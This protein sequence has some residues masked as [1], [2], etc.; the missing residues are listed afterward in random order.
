MAKVRATVEEAQLSLMSIS[1]STHWR[2]Q[3][4]PFN[5]YRKMSKALAGIPPNDYQK[6][7]RLNKQGC[8][9]IENGVRITDI[10]CEQIGFDSSSYFAKCFK[11]QFGVLPKDYH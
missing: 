9:V 7:I 3:Y 11:I 5:F 6:T 8:Q 1:L 4:E 2:P 10:V